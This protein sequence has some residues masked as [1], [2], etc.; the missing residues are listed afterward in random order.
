MGGPARRGKVVL[1]LGI[2]VLQKRLER[3]DAIGAKVDE[4]V[5]RL[6]LGGADSGGGL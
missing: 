1:E 5:A 3:V 6:V 2:G 4:D